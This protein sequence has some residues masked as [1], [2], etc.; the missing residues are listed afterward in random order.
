MTASSEVAVIGAGVVG[1]STALALVDRGVGVTVYERGMPG[2]GQSGGRSRLFRHAHDDPRLVAH[3]RTSRALWSRWEERFGV[4]LVSP[5][6][7]VAIGA[8]VEHRLEVLRRVGGVPARAID[9]AELSERLPLL[10]PYTGPAMLDEGGGAIRADTAVATLVAHLGDVLVADEV[11]AVRP[12][13]RGTVEVRAGGTR[14]EYDA[15]VVCAGH[16]SGQ[17]AGGVGISLPVRLAAHTRV[18]FTVRGHP[19]PRLA[20]LQDSS[21]AF[22]EAAVYAAATAGNR[23]YALGVS[24]NVPAQADGGI[25]AR[26][27][28]EL[29][30]R[31]CRYVAR[32]LPGLHAHAAGHRHCWVTDL[33]WAEDGVAVWEAGRIFFVAGHNLFKLAPWLGQTLAGAAAGDPLPAD[34]RPGA[35]LGAP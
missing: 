4:E 1:L 29:G 9:T 8:A 20:C 18:T 24:R 10:A 34:L 23:H 31:A 17:L 13:S 14:S 6:G 21:G 33:P 32:A 35:R 30:D 3:A 19:P 7:V 2:N 5:D 12:T 15:A 22:G 25:A 11:I 28:A 26:S 27:L 16:R